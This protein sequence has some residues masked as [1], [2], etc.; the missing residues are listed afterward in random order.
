[1]ITLYGIKDKGRVPFAQSVDWAE[2]W[3]WR[4]TKGVP[5][6]FVSLKAGGILWIPKENINDFLAPSFS[7][8]QPH[9]VFQKKDVAPNGKAK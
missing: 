8:P 1:M 5:R 4:R 6:P 3:R 9:I 2:F 7:M